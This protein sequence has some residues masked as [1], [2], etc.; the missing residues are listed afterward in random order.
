MMT[1]EQNSTP[2]PRLGQVQYIIWNDV[3]ANP[4]KPAIAITIVIAIAA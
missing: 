2:V 1:Q 4:S 3:S